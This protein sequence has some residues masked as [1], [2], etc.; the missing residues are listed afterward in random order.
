M[1]NKLTPQKAKQQEE[2]ERWQCKTCPA[3]AQEH[4]PYCL[5][6]QLYWEDYHY[7]K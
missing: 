4:S 2:E 6:C 5:S 7:E 1:R 3:P